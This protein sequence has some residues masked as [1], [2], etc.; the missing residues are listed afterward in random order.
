MRKEKEENN[1]EIIYCVLERP[2]TDMLFFERPK[3]LLKAA[4]SGGESECVGDKVGM[5]EEDGD[6][7]AELG[8][9]SCKDATL[10]VESRTNKKKMMNSFDLIRTLSAIRRICLANFMEMMI[11][12]DV[13][14]AKLNEETGP[15]PAERGENF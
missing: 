4:S 12:G 5:G 14:S 1:L 9:P 15:R 3:H 10:L 6:F 13:A 2:L 8:I 11:E 7:A